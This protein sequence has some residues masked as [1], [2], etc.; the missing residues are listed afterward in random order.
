M[1]QLD[2]ALVCT[3]RQGLPGSFDEA[4]LEAARRSPKARLPFRRTACTQGHSCAAHGQAYPPNKA[5]SSGHEEG[6]R[7]V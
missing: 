7:S 1:L 6:G 4:L 2:N 5:S 3:S